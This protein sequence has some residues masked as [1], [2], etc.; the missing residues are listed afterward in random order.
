MRKSTNKTIRKVALLLASKDI[1]SCVDKAPRTEVSSVVAS[2]IQNWLVYQTYS[3]MFCSNPGSSEQ[4]NLATPQ[5]ALYHSFCRNN[6]MFRAW[7]L[8]FTL[9]T[10]SATWKKKKKPRV[11]KPDPHVFEYN[12][13]I[14]ILF[15]IPK[16]T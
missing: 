13:T 16:I 8:G 12:R 10:M 4:D 6:S 3:Q 7:N 2:K 15:S 11:V 14:Q 1:R 5:N 9:D